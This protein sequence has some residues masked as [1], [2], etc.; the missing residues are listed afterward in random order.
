M[1][2]L[3]PLMKNGRS[4]WNAEA[5]PREEFQERLAAVQ[6]SMSAV[7]I[8]L[9]LVYGVPFNAKADPCY[10]SNFVNV[11]ARGEMVAVP[12]QGEPTLF[13]N[14]F[15]RALPTVRTITW[16]KDVRPGGD[17]A[18]LLSSY[19][20]DATHSSKVIGLAGLRLHMPFLQYRAVRK[21]LEGREVREVD[22]LVA[23]LR[24]VKSPC[25]LG[26]VRA[27]GK[28]VAS[29]WAR[30][31]GLEPPLNERLVH[32]QARL[33]ARLQGAED[34]RFLIARPSEG[35]W[36]LRYPE[37]RPLADGARVFIYIAAEVDR[38]WAESA[39][40]FGVQSGR[41]V[42]LHPDLP[43]AIYQSMLRAAAPGDRASAPV[44][45]ALA[46]AA[47]AG[48]MLA[49]DYG[50]GNGVGLSLDEA[51]VIVENSPDSFLPGMCLSLRLTTHDFGGIICC[52]TLT[53]TSSSN[54][55]LTGV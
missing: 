8:D 51:P 39:H 32:T 27:A 36:G 22:G 21:A 31:G 12:R 29:L 9:L 41:L 23:E 10:L 20:D 3:Q 24:R 34:V 50:W 53:I 4:V 43:S 54:E 55:I 30:L 16:I 14:V 11:L 52:D 28:V 42:E 40:T 35:E 47:G 7:G 48:C 37:P 18:S 13:A 5:L 15:P 38:Y 17:F 1:Q 49:D 19:L 33:A 25:E 46:A 6:A 26:R 2:I 44:R 45:Q